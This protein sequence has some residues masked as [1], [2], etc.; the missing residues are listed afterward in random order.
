MK[1]KYCT[2]CGKEHCNRCSSK[3]IQSTMYLIVCK[4]CK[5]GFGGNYRSNFCPYCGAS[6][7]EENIDNKIGRAHV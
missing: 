1:V 4:K 2:K 7:N 5:A 3:H 6:L